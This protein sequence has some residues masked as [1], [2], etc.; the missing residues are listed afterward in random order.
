M[1]PSISDYIAAVESAADTLNDLNYLRPVLKADGQ[2]Y[3][4]SGNFAVVFKMQDSHTGD[5]MALKCF[6]RDVPDRARRLRLIGEWIAE[7]PSPY[8]LPMTYHPAELWVDCTHCDREEFDVVLMPWVEG[9]TLGECYTKDGHRSKMIF[10]SSSFYKAF[11]EFVS[12]LLAQP[13]AHGDL[14]PDNIIVRYTDDSITLI[15]YDGCFV[16]ALTG[17]QAIEIG[18]PP[19]RH[20]NRTVNDFN[21]H[22]DDFSILVLNLELTYTPL[23]FNK[24][25]FLYY[26]NSDLFDELL[27][28]SSYLKEQSRATIVKI[29]SFLKEVLV[30]E[31]CSD[32][33]Y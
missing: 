24:D 8:L 18:I 28:K 31:P 32:N 25:R 14:K 5:H 20:P 27:N 16:P 19:Y 17:E 10:E 22:I 13:F 21:R 30:N 7:N 33:R 12:W 2:P 4:S 29:L 15:D 3:F 11:E 9:M 26:T 6:L 1:F 23:H